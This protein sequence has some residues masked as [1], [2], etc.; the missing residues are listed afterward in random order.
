MRVVIHL[1]ANIYLL[2]HLVCSVSFLRPLSPYH[3]PSLFLFLF[4]LS[5][6]LID[7][8]FIFWDTRLNV[9]TSSSPW[10]LNSAISFLCVSFSFFSISSSLS[11]HLSSLFYLRIYKYLVSFPIFNCAITR[12]NCFFH[13]Q[14]YVN[15]VDGLSLP[16]HG[17]SVVQVVRPLIGQ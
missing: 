7:A 1:R 5:I 15:V 14:C 9:K 6:L 11:S 10:T 3:L 12:Y 2:F 13:C 4:F 17:G 16:P 8:S